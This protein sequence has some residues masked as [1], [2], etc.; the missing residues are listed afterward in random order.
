ML[1]KQGYSAWLAQK[2]SKEKLTRERLDLLDRFNAVLSERGVTTIGDISDADIIELCRPWNVSGRRNFLH[3]IA[4]FLNDYVKYARKENTAQLPL[5][6]TIEHYYEKGYESAAKHA[7]QKR[8]GNI[9][10]PPDTFKVN[11]TFLGGLDNDTFVTAF[12]EL[13][14]FVIRCY[15][16]IEN[17]PF[18][19]GYPD[20]ETTDGYYNRVM[21]ILFAV[22]LCGTYENGS[23]I[24]DGAKFFAHKLIKRHKKV[25]QTI[26][27]F[28]QMG[29]RFE[30]Y[31]KRA[32]SFRV[33][34]PDNPPV[35]ML[36]CAYVRNINTSLADWAWGDALKSLSYRYVQ[37]PS[38][39]PFHHIFHA[40][41]DYAS[42]TLREIQE[43]LYHEAEKYGFSIDPK[44]PNNIS[45]KKGSKQFL[46]VKEENGKIT[47]KAS[48][49]HAFEREPD[50]MQVF[51]D[52]FPHV[53]RLDDPGLCCNDK[54]PGINQ[55]TFAD[56]SET[57]GKRCA[58]RMKFTF[59]GT[60]YKRCGLANFIFP[61]LTFD[62][63][64]AILLMY[65]IENKIK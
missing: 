64:K 37:D 43:W 18:T 41:M 6:D 16:D 1:D 54:N 35:A 51:C 61:D 63:V 2:K 28:E 22:G 33:Y 9:L 20:Y 31:G 60:T 40:E 13:Q 27:G 65:L 11:P 23:I 59:N 48:F 4:S 49:I 10:P 7:V 25:E 44:S 12:K 53:F 34:Y 50:K 52:R 58:F 3:N 15:N 42:D 38:E 26:T 46:S 14:G 57:D 56:K 36:L 17:T 39:Q 5:A 30:G 62:D 29:L 55:H 19:W 45:F 24:V 8:R 47:T 21:D 32:A